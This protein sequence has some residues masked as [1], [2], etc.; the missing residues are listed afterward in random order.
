MPAT[1]RPAD[2]NHWGVNLQRRLRGAGVAQKE[3]AE[4]WGVHPSRITQFM[5]HP[6]PVEMSYR[7]FEILASLLQTPADELAREVYSNFPGQSPREHAGPE[8]APADQLVAIPGLPPLSSIAPPRPPIRTDR[9]PL[10]EHRFSLQH[11]SLAVTLALSDSNPAN[12][13][14]LTEL[15]YSCLQ[16]VNDLLHAALRDRDDD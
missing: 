5:K 8:A 1:E 13:R 10:T 14:V 7:R 11:G 16:A 6:T 15:A 2:P 3:L 9:R 4:A 12:T